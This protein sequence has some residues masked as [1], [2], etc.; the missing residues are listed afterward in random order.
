VAGADAA[1]R[2]V[3]AG[4]RQALLLT[5]SRTVADLRRNPRVVTAPLKDWMESL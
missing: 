1:V 4:L 2:T 3:V 5:S